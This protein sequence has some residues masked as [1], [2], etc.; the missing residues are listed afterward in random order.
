MIFLLIILTIVIFSFISQFFSKYNRVFIFTSILFVLFFYYFLAHL[1]NRDEI[2]SF[3]YRDSVY[4]NRLVKAFKE[5]NLH[6]AKDPNPIPQNQNARQLYVEAVTKNHALFWLWDC[7]YYKGYIYIYFGL[8][9]VLLFYLPFNL[10]TNSFLPDQI[11]ILIL[12]SIIF[13]I[14]LLIIRKISTVFLHLKIPL[15]I[16]ILT[17]F[18]IG[19]SDFTIFFLVQP[20][21]YE[22]SIISAGLLLLLGIYLFLQYCC[23]TNIKK[24]RYY[25]FFIGLVLALSVGCRP[26]YILFIPLFFIAIL[27]FEYSRKTHVKKIIKYSLFFII[28]CLLYG[29]ILATYNY[30]RFD[31]IFEFGWKYQLNDIPIY[32]NIFPIKDFLLGLKYHIFQVPLISENLPIFFSVKAVGHSLANEKTIGLIFVFPLSIFLLLLPKIIHCFWIR[33]EKHILV[34]LFLSIY[35]LI[36]NLFIVCMAGMTLRYNF[37]YIYIISILSIFVFYIIYTKSKIK[38][39]FILS[40]LFITLFIFSLY[41]NFSILL[42]DNYITFYPSEY[43]TKII[44]FLM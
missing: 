24:N 22:V 17:I 39:K 26:H 5:Y 11:V 35:I 20:H 25:I 15:W 2:N 42:N 27:Y 13:L 37:E 18:L 41:I 31:S 28:P 21:I 12:A 14:S 9:P 8:T 4:Y 32:T 6:I 33:K 7:S 34:F 23:S 43:K 29:S 1:H 40:T 19:I 3:K 30:L 16:Q 36:I 44:L 10:I 38:I